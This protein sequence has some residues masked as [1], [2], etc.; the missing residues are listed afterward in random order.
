[1]PT[2]RSN[3]EVGKSFAIGTKI[4]YDGKLYEVVQGKYCNDC[5]IASI[6]LVLLHI[7]YH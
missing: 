2:N 3:N 4:E 6:Y 7:I 5:S 1:M